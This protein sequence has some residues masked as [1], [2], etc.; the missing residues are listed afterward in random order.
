MFGW[1]SAW[2]QT[3]PTPSLQL[4]E[5]ASVSKDQGV[6]DVGA[7]ASALVDSLLDADL[8]GWR[9]WTFAPPRWTT[10]GNTSIARSW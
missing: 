9:R 5:A 4:I 10:P 2:Y 1:F 6:I 3:R 8:P 7:G